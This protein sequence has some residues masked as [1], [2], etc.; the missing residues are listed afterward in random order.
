MNLRQKAM[1]YSGSG[2]RPGGRSI[3]YPAFASLGC[4]KSQIAA[5]PMNVL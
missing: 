5:L 4:G 3:E 1:L 2:R